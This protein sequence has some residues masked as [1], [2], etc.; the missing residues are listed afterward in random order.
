MDKDRNEQD[1]HKGSEALFFFFLPKLYFHV[2][3]IYKYYDRK[4]KSEKMS[5]LMRNGQMYNVL[6]TVS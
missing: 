4:Y 3:G 1:I 5:Q 2:R 6:I